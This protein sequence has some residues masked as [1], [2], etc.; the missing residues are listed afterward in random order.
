VVDNSSKIQELLK[1]QY[2]YGPNYK[3]SEEKRIGI[4]LFSGNSNSAFYELWGETQIFRLVIIKPSSNLYTNR[5]VGKGHLLFLLIE[6]DE[7]ITGGFLSVESERPAFSSVFS[8]LSEKGNSE[9]E[10]L[11]LEFVKDHYGALA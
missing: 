7:K 8:H 9:L 1:E 5:F 6:E 3:M 11:W 2:L 10:Q 4:N